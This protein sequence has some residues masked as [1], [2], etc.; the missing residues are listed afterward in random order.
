MLL[1]KLILKLTYRVWNKEMCSLFHAA[2]K[3]GI[4]NAREM[5]ELIAWFD[6]RIRTKVYAPRKSF[7]EIFPPEFKTFRNQL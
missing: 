1:R 7:T 2:Q 6:P 4:I 5:V 3:E